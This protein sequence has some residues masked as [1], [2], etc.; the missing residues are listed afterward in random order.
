MF[1]FKRPIISYHFRPTHDENVTQNMAT[2]NLRNVKLAY[3]S[4]YLDS[5]H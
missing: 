3:R 2:A 5:F 4:P 1:I